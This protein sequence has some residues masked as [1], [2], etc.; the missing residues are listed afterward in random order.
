M[1]LQ[2]I[3]AK[4]CQRCKWWEMETASIQHHNSYSR[5]KEILRV[6]CYLKSPPRRCRKDRCGE[7][8]QVKDVSMEM[9]GVG[10]TGVEK[11]CRCS[12]AGK[13][14]TRGGAGRGGAVIWGVEEVAPSPL[15]PGTNK[16]EVS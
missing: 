8:M 9:S 7:D 15:N 12:G 10:R 11:T 5:G 3:H 6:V 13:A 16:Q 2:M 14:G 4:K 1:P